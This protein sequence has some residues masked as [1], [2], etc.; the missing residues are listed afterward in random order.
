MKSGKLRV[1]R[2]GSGAKAPPLAAHPNSQGIHTDASSSNHQAQYL[3]YVRM[4]GKIQLSQKTIDMCVYTK[5][6]PFLLFGL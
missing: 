2:G 6:T 3:N 1:A 5:M 4:A